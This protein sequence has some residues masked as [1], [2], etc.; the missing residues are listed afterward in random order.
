VLEEFAQH[1]WGGTNKP[2]EMIEAAGQLHRHS[3]RI[4][5]EFTKYRDAVAVFLDEL[6]RRVRDAL[7]PYMTLGSEAAANSER[8]Y[9]CA[10]L[11]A[12]EKPLTSDVLCIL[13]RSCRSSQI[14]RPTDSPL[15]RQS[16]A[17][18]TRSK[19]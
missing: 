16:V 13:D 6:L 1:P 10:T 9:G 14:P 17:S 12:C 18:K 11:S 2:I 19:L 7:D 8:L 15:R 5:D 3:N 4:I